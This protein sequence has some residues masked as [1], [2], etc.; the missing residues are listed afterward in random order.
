MFAIV[1]EHVLIRAFEMPIHYAG[2]IVS[3]IIELVALILLVYGIFV[4]KEAYLTPYLT[5]E[6]IPIDYLYL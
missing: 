4:E 2:T 6:V 1:L 3:G 5:V